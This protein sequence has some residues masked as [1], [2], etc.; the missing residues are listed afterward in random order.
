MILLRAEWTVKSLVFLATITLFV[1]YRRHQM[2]CILF[3]EI[4]GCITNGMDPTVNVHF[5]MLRGEK[6]LDLLRRWYFRKMAWIIKHA[7][8]LESLSEKSK[9]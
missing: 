5:S 2:N 4:Y 3:K 9:A 7:I 1:S 8:K 6:K